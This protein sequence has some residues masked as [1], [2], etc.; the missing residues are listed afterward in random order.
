MSVFKKMAQ[1]KLDNDKNMQED[2]IASNSNHDS[3]N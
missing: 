1:S 2:S 3:D